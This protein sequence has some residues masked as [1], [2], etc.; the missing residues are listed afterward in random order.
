MKTLKDPDSQDFAMDVQCW[1]IKCPHWV[2]WNPTNYTFWTLA[3]ETNGYRY[4]GT[5]IYRVNMF[6]KGSG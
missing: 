1:S 2:H 5:Y 4:A 6:L 3:V